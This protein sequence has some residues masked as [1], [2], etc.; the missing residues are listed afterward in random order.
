MRENPLLA[1]MTT[2]GGKHRRSSANDF[3]EQ[4]DVKNMYQMVRPGDSV[5]DSADT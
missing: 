4:A 1:E 3:S 5:A 2:G